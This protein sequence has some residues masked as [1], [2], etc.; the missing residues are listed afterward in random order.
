[1]MMLCWGTP[2]CMRRDLKPENFL[3]TSKTGE[4]ELKLTDFGLG[5]QGNTTAAGQQDSSTC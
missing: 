2:H 1:M 4:A 5:K 3:L